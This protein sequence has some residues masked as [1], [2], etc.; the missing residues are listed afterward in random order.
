MSLPSKSTFV[1]LYY[2]LAN[3]LEQ[4]IDSGEYPPATRLPTEAQLS[5]EFG[6]SIITA[7]NA[8][9][10]LT[11]K[12][13]IQ[14]FAG[15]GSFVIERS[16]VRSPWGFGSIDDIVMTTAN[17]E[18]ATLS[19]GIVEA[20]GWVLKSFKLSAPTSVHW[21]RNVR[22]VG[23]KRF[24]VSDVYHHPNLTQIVRAPKF[25]KLVKQKKLVVMAVCEMAGTSLGEIK[26][27]L[28]AA[29]SSSDIAAT[30]LIKRGLPLLVVERVFLSADGEVLQVGRTHYRVDQFQYDLNLRPMEEVSQV[31]PSPRRKLITKNKST[32]RAV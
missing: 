26:Q 30:L 17:S 23:G 1:P 18:L 15:R 21:M 24:M 11:D 4:R 8:M 28:S 32:N 9:K 2:Q 27:S 25:R 14:R 5:T 12:G 16:P 20:P 3:L 13:R 19:T 10:I 6:V 22:S 29:V 31:D 7:R